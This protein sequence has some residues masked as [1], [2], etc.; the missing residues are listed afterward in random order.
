MWPFL[1]TGGGG[2]FVYACLPPTLPYCLGRRMNWA[3]HFMG[4]HCLLVPGPA[5]G[6]GLLPCL[7]CQTPFLP[8]WRWGRWTATFTMPFSSHIPLPSPSLQD[9]SPLPQSDACLPFGICLGCRLLGSPSCPCRFY[10]PC[11]LPHPCALPA[12]QTG[13]D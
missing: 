12:C 9:C 11:A 13:Q 10:L 1:V 6:M 8:F 7:F 3:R 2:G 4:W 5:L